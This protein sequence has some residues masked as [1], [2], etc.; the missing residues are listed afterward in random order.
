MDE[1]NNLLTET[2]WTEINLK[3]KKKTVDTLLDMLIMAYM[4]GVADVRKSLNEDIAVDRKQMEESIYRKIDG[5]DWTERIYD[6]ETIPDI[7]RIARTE[8]NRVFSEGQENTAIKGGATE[9][10]WNTM[11]DDRVRD[12]H[13]YLEGDV[14]PIDDWFYTLAGERAKHPMGFGVP[15]E[16]C[17]CRC[18]L[19]YRKR[20]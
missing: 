1:L 16:D 4:L 10:I 6:A 12:S 3:D 5:K 8:G 7:E 18:W 17:N 9:K 13:W 15:E 20:G 2:E 11:M 19:T 14:K